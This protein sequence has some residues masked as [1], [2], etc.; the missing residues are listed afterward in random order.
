MPARVCRQG[1]LRSQKEMK[2]FEGK[3]PTERNKIIAAIALGATALL[4]LTYTFSGMFVS[5]SKTTVT[6]TASP[7]PTVLLKTGDTQ[8]T[9]LPT[10]EQVNFD[11]TTTPVIYN[12]NK[13]YAPD[14]GRNIF[15]FYEPPPYIAPPPVEKTPLPYVPPPTPTPTPIPLMLVGFITPQNVFAGSK[16]FRLEVNGDKFTPDSAIYF[17]GNPLPT[18]YLSSQKLTADIPT[19]FIAG[20]GFIQ[21]LVRTPD[22][23]LYSNQV[24]LTVQAPPRPQLDYIGM[25]ARKRYNNDTAYF[26]EQ[27]KENSKPFGARLNDVV[28][29]RFRLTSISAEEVVLEDI[30]LGFKHKIALYRVVPGQDPNS[31]GN[32]RGGNPQYNINPNLPN[33]TPPQGEI[34]GPRYNQTPQPQKQTDKDDDDGDN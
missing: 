4:A 15:A 31:R 9:T 24:A 8:N 11:Y 34:P 13:F 2:L 17:N 5:S 23:K 33:Y 21:I 12:R 20:E 28:S 6:V 26:Q 18:N 3:T 32:Q 29:G 30:S 19:N 16:G 7:T 1:C 25:I 27:G 22:S 10:D 14:A